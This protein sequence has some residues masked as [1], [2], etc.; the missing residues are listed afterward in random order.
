[1]NVLFMEG[2]G[3]LEEPFRVS[4]P[5]ERTNL[6]NFTISTPWSIPIPQPSIYH[7]GYF[8]ELSL[9]WVLSVNCFYHSY[10]ATC[11]GIRSGFLCPNNSMSTPSSTFYHSVICSNSLSAEALLSSPC[12]FRFI[13]FYSRKFSGGLGERGD[14]HVSSICLL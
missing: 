12:P 5:E 8:W 13:A 14:K 3:E 6:E 10:Y 9:S 11:M 4:F 7:T 1:M 2:P